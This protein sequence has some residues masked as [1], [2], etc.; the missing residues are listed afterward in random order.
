M[1]VVREVVA[2]VVVVGEV[3]AVEVG[4]VTWQSAKAPCA[5]AVVISLSTVSVAAAPAIVS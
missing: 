1:V 4:V 2:V 5:N 3:V